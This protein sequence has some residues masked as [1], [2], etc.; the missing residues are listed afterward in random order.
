[1]NALVM[2]PFVMFFMVFAM[3]YPP[4]AILYA[5][6]TLLIRYKEEEA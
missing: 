5:I 2:S 3:Q 6:M 4:K 1:M